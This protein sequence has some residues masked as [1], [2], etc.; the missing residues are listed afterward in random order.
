MT[1]KILSILLVL[2]MLLTIVPT[3]FADPTPDDDAEYIYDGLVY[4]IIDNEISIVGY[5]KDIAS[6]VLIPDSI[7]GY[8]VTEISYHAFFC[9]GRP[10]EGEECG[11]SGIIKSVVIGENVKVIRANAFDTCMSLENI[12]ISDSVEEIRLHAFFCCPNLKS[13]TI[14]RGV[15]YIGEFAFGSAADNV[16]YYGTE[17]DWNLI[18]TA[19]NGF[20]TGLENATFHFISSEISAPTCVDQGYTTY[21]CTCGDVYVADYVDA[22]GHTEEIIP[23]VPATYTE[24][25]LT[26]GKKCSVC[27]TVLVEQTEIP[28]LINPNLTTENENITVEEN[29]VTLTPEMSVADIIAN[30]ENENVQILDKDGKAIENDKLVG[31]GG[32]IQV[33]DNEGNVLSNYDV[34]VSADV[35]GDATITAADA[36]LALRASASLDKIEGVYAIA[37]NYNG[38]GDITAADARQI[39][40][41]S[42]GL[43]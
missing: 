42:A 40:R 4:E 8:P 41:K 34:V 32:K 27:N 30:V 13:V 26:E 19:E 2:A 9:D 14:G 3:V 25:G 22:T 6:D 7:D 17:N 24:T 36:R 20:P 37:A 38:D 21:C 43:E 35:N 1:K 33:L 5:T 12:V 15:K 29:G 10:S 39:L 16:Y 31:T 11:E 28:M 23:E 18:Q